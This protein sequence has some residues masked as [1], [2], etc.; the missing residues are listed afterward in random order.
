LSLINYVYVEDTGS[1]DNTPEIIRNHLKSIGMPGHVHETKWVDFAFNRSE[2][3][4]RGRMTPGID[5]L[6]MIDADEVLVF[7]TKEVVDRIQELK[8]R[9]VH[10]CYYIQTRYGGATYGRP[11]ITSTK[12]DFYYRGV[13]HE[14]LDCPGDFSS[15]NL[16][17]IFNKPIQDGARSKDTNRYAKDAEIL[18][19]AMK[20]EKD[21]KMVSRYSF[22]CAQS[23]RDAANP[24]KAL[25]GYLKAAE[26]CEWSQEKYFSLYQAAK[27]KLTLNYPP[28]QVLITLGAATQIVNTRGE[29]GHEAMRLCRENKWWALGYAIGKQAIKTSP[30][31]EDLFSEKWVYDYAIKDEMS[32]IAY[33]YGDYELSEKLSQ[34]LLDEKK[35]PPTYEPRIKANLL[36]ARNILSHGTLKHD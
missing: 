19:Q 29:A 36:Y 23:W 13:L 28:E 34:Q 9:M 6:L 26:I 14:F 22:Y 2:A 15:G 32:I 30:K 10:D 31:D 7:Q 20:T 25:A 4:R 21:P 3:L 8:D 1:T 11:Q 33:W 16:Q 18:E 35:Y 27:L 12:K 17:N 5:Y 24:R